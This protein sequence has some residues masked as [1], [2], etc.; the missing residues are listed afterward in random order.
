MDPGMQPFLMIHLKDTDSFIGIIIR[1]TAPL[2]VK[3]TKKD[4]EYT[5]ITYK[6]IKIVMKLELKTIL[7]NLPRSNIPRC[8]I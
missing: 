4:E 1:N 5:I 3:L 6:I 2:E 8:F 7:V